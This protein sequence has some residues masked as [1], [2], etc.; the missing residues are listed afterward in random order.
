MR[1]AIC[2]SGQ[3][4]TWKQCYTSWKNVIQQ[5]KSHPK[6]ENEIIEIDCFIH[7]W[8]FNTIPLSVISDVNNP[9]TLIDDV[10]LETLKKLLKPK[11][12]IIEDYDKSKSRFDFV[13]IRANKLREGNNEGSVLWWAASALYSIMRAGE[14]KSDYEM[15][16]NFVYDV[17]VKMRLDGV[18]DQHNINILLNDFN[19]PLK[20]KTIYSMHSK[21]LGHFPFE[22]VGD[23]FFYSDSETYNVLASLFYWISVLQNNIFSKGVKVEEILGFYIR[24]F[25]IQNIRSLVNVDII[26]DNIKK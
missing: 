12:I 25:D 22:L 21:G 13:N 1:I 18:F 9:P 23:I 5:L 19:P 15:E 14:L 10:E 8:N 17:C 2:F 20:R 4:R 24:M 11:K 6:F 16:N 7:T 26:R 3:P